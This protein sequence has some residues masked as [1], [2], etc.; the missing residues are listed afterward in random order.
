MKWLVGV[1]AFVGLL[2]SL[3][4]SWPF[5]GLYYYYYYIGLYLVVVSLWSICRNDV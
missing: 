2:L 5:A 1:A 3:A 4:A